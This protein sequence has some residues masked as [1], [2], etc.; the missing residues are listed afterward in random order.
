VKKKVVLAGG[1]GFIG[2]YFSKQFEEKGYDIHI[3]SRQAQHISWSDRTAIVEALEGAELLINLAGKS[4]NCRYNE[5]NKKAIMDSRTETTTI[6]GKAILA[7]NNPPKVWMNSSTATIYRHAEDRPMTEDGGEIGSGFSVDVATK[8]EET[9]FS[10]DL[11]STRQVALRI[12]IV[13]G[14]GGGVMTP[15]LNLVKFG[16]GGIQGSGRQMFS[17]IHVE[18]LYQIVLFL[19]GREDLTG[20]F[21]CAAPEPVSNRELMSQLRATMNA[22]FGLPAQKWMLEI[23]SLFLRTETELVLKS[24]WVIPERLE[25]EGYTFTYPTLRE[26]L[27]NII[28]D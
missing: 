14:K 23:G 3:I 28:N 5:A 10:F 21:N 15:Y 25:R 7:C 9:F 20:V 13:L 17:W 1:T 22:R 11:P 18:D 4:V 26:T 27:E 8:W 19:R 24:R 16:L 6:L 12:A 2:Q